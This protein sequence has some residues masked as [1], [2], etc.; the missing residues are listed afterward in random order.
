VRAGK[1]R[2]KRSEGRG[3]VRSPKSEIRSPKKPGSD[4]GPARCAGA[5]LASSQ[6]LDCKWIQ[7]PNRGIRGTRGKPRSGCACLS[8]GER[9]V[10]CHDRKSSGSTWRAL[11]RE[12]ARAESGTSRAHQ[13]SSLEARSPSS[14][15]R[16][17]RA[18][19]RWGWLAGA[20]RAGA[21]GNAGGCSRRGG[22]NARRIHGHIT[23]D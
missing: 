20:S 17:A 12:A 16:E 4:A 3:E 5:G 2:L 11:S 18:K 7:F 23:G 13:R 19:R 9:K 10:Q 14:D 1:A 15:Q 22:V 21:R 8:R 6:Q